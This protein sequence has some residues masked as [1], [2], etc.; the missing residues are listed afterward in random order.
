MYAIVDANNF[1]ASCERLF[2]PALAHTPVVVLSNN[3][4]CVIARSNE[5][6]ALGLAMGTPYFQ[7]KPLIHAHGIKVFSS[8]YAFYGDMSNRIM[9]VLESHWPDTEVYSIDEAFL[10]LT[11][12][13]HTQQTAF[14]AQMQK[15]IQRNTG[16]PVSIGIGPSKTLAKLANHIAKKHVRRPVFNITE[17][18]A[19]LKQIDVS[20]V[21]GVGRQ[22]GKKLRR[23]GIYTADDL[24]M[25]DAK[26]FK[27]KFN[28]VLERTILELRGIPCVDTE[29][30]QPKQNIMSS[31]SFGQL[32]TEYHAIAEALSSY[33]AIAVEKM[34]RQHS[35]AMSLS[36]F[37]RTNPFRKDLPYY[38]QS[39]G[40]QFS[41]PSDDIR[42]I[43][44]YA[45]QCLASIYREGFHY[46]KVGIL[47][48][49]L[50]SNR[51]QQYELF[52]PQSTAAKQQSKQFM[53]V[54][55]DINQRFGRH[56]IHLAAEGVTKVQRWHMKSAFM[57]PRYTTNW[58]ELPRVYAR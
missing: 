40:L 48:G 11:T 9:S 49:D 10:C 26:T 33:A 37:L 2:Q 35:L 15:K 29:M 21:W 8:N 7:I 17:E 4:G 50:S 54:L 42:T 36:V 53:Q 24:R 56:S 5:A 34:R 45:K 46:K 32:Q 20:D 58:E 18:Q 44:Q 28:V 43:T 25:A 57:S 47:L 23:L 52:H 1:Y 13:A 3:D 51:Q 22:W 38:S 31:K 16:I 39:A 12:L 55:T 41:H 19:W 14:C 27:R 6:K 30:L